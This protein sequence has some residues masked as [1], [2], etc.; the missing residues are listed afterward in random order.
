MPTRK[1]FFESCFAMILAGLG[2][3]LL[4]GKKGDEVK[5]E[6]KKEGGSLGFQQIQMSDLETPYCR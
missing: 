3:P 5:K 1:E 6:E 2:S 4:L